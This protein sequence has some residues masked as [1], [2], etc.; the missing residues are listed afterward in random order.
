LRRHPALC[1]RAG[2][3]GRHAAPPGLGTPDLPAGRGWSLG[4]RLAAVPARPDAGPV[5]VPGGTT[6]SDLVALVAAPAR[7]PDRPGGRLPEPQPEPR[8]QPRRRRRE[9]KVPNARTRVA[10]P[11]LPDV[12]TDAQ[13]SEA[14]S[15]RPRPGLRAAAGLPRA[16]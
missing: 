5:P 14:R 12:A 16:I 11:D 7:H 9:T 6:A 4:R 1:G 10:A 15:P 2:G 8:P 13:R 3:P